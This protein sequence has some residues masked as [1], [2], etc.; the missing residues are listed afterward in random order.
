LRQPIIIGVAGGSGSGKTT[1]S[2]AILERVGR[3]R[4]AF[5]QHDSY[6]RELSHLAYEERTRVNFDHPDSLD[7][8]LL[9]AHLDALC[10]AQAVEVPIYDFTRHNRRPET[11]RVS[12]HPVVLVEGI[13]IF[14]ERAL[15]DRMDVKIYV[16]ADADLRFIRRLNRDIS[17]RGRTVQSVIDQYMTTVRP[18][19]L[20]F[21]E[22]SKRYADIIIPRG[23]MNAVAIDMVVARVEALLVAHTAWPDSNASIPLG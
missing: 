14:A 8:E 21:V 13:L 23:G 3:E 1:V 18:M 15:R 2:H 19:H 9:I 12:P 6:Y 5:M 22:P 11:V 4:I 20:E 7:N 17:E 10:D 16:D